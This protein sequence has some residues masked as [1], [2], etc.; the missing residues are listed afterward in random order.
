[1][2][3][4]RKPELQK[5]YAYNHQSQVDLLFFQQNS[6]QQSLIMFFVI[7]FNNYLIAF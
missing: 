6:D 2:S 1:M 3:S 7:I 5:W 4:Y